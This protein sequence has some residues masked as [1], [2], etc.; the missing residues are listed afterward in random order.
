M[1]SRGPNL[2]NPFGLVQPDSTYYTVGT[3]LLYFR[4]PPP[5]TA[6]KEELRRSRGTSWGD[7]RRWDFLPWVAANGE[8]RFEGK[9]DAHC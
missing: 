4:T 2:F 9:G 5:T 7:R 6:E 3:T 1:G 8:S